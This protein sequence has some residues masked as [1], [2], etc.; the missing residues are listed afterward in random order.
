MPS[1]ACET[2]FAAVRGNDEDAAGDAAMKNKKEEW[3][4]IKPH[5]NHSVGAPSNLML[6]QENPYASD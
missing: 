2:R 3:G 6:T 4:S 5:L 1:P